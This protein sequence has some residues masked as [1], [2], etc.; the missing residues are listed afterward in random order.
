MKGSNYLFL[1]SVL[2]VHCEEPFETKPS[3][4]DELFTLT[5]NYDGRRLVDKTPIKISW[6]NITLNNFKEFVV[7]RT[8]IE[9]NEHHWTQIT[10]LSDSLA[11]SYIDTIDDELTYQY[12]LRIV[13]KGD[14]YRHAVAE[15]FTVPPTTKIVVPDDYLFIQDA[16]DT[17]FM[18]SG[19]TLLVM[20]GDYRDN[21]KF[22]EKEILI[23]SLYGPSITRLKPFIDTLSIV[24][25][26]KGT[27]QGF[28]I[29]G[30]RSLEEPGLKA[31]GNAQINNCVIEKNKFGAI[32]SDSATVSFSNI[33][34]NG[35]G[36]G[37]TLMGICQIDN[38]LIS[39]NESSG[40][41]LY[42]QSALVKN[43]RVRKNRSTGTGGGIRIRCREVIIL[44]TI[45]DNNSAIKGGAISS[46][47]GT[48]TTFINCIVFGNSTHDME[49]GHFA[50][51]GNIQI[52]NSIIWA[53]SIESQ[54]KLFAMNAFY[55]NIQGLR[56]ALT[57][58]NI[59]TNPLFINPKSGDF[60]LQENSPCIDAGH[61]GD[62]YRD[63]DGSR[64]DMGIYGGPWGE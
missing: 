13:D 19:D 45:I 28:T 10:T 62:E 50:I 21:F 30:V 51:I 9:K 38:C 60:H 33:S 39:Y 26:H 34:R 37:I 1:I 12:R 49:D 2:F 4:K 59:E 40:I 36:G 3:E 46:G 29:S 11:T 24:E 58:H 57:N 27:L 22:V 35:K 56:P 43:C 53:N 64:N 5:H 47:Y 17:K 61:P 15:P 44:N 54:K 8:Y 48:H 63:K 16:Y 23:K 14:Q 55:S 32:I 20:G 6:T 25:I 7:E 41:I 31:Y 18:D 52:I 42:G